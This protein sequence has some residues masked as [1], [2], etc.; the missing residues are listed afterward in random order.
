MARKKEVHGHLIIPVCHA[1]AKWNTRVHLGK[2]RDA[3]RCQGRKEIHEGRLLGMAHRKK[4]VH[5]HLFIPVSHA[6][7]KWNTRVHLGKTRDAYRCQGR[8]EIHEGKVLGDGP[9]SA[10]QRRSGTRGSTWAR[11]GMLIVA[12][13]ER[14]FTK[15][16][17]LGMAHRYG[18]CIRQ[19]EGM[20]CIEYTP[21]ADTNSYSFNAIDA[22]STSQTSILNTA[23]AA[24]D[25]IGIEEGN[26][27]KGKFE[28][29]CSMVRSFLVV[30]LANA[31]FHSRTIVRMSSP[32]QDTGAN[33]ACIRVVERR[34]ISISRVE[35]PTVGQQ[36]KRD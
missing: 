3:Y 8:K 6:A 18:I 10:M 17:F 32:P 7:A 33:R 22:I 16:R 35:G 14:R 4:E 20:C 26:D 21:C 27:Q 1:A 30:S 24:F 15:A 36:A 19:E 11:R 34:L 13:E 28:T 9:Q 12:R 5:G 2:T 25:Y 23:C 29:K 31:E